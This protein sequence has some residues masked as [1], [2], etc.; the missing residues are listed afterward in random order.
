VE[1]IA[2]VGC[3][4]SGKSRLARVLGARLGIT[5]VHLDA[6]YYDK[7]WK[8]LDQEAFAS[9]QRQLVTAPRRIIDGNYASTLPIRLEAADTV[10]LLDLPGWACLRGIAV[11]RLRHGGGQH[12]TIG[13]YDRITWGFVRYILGY[14]K[15]MAP[16]VRALI[17]SHARGAQVTVLRSRAAVRSYLADQVA[18]AHFS[19]QAAAGHEN[20][21]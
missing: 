4:G 21:C 8:A 11:R 17:T 12:Q 10:I 14:R 2:I 15:S 3:G 16:R 6:L 19:A 7:D 1:R 20:R 18:A 9:L 13:V 5:P